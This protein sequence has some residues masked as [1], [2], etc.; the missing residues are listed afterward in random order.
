MNTVTERDVA[1]L[2]R[3]EVT[4]AI[5]EK[6]ILLSVMDGLSVAIGIFIDVAKHHGLSAEKAAWCIKAAWDADKETWEIPQ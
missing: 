2:K 6:L 5:V 3:A 4:K 1:L